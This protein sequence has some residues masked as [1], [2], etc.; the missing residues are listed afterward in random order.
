MN[1]T[2]TRSL[3]SA[4]ALVSTAAFAT[5]FH[6]APNG[7]DANPGTQAK[8]F[9]TLE[10]ARDAIRELKQ[11]GP[12]KEP[13]TVRLG[14]GRYALAREV[15]FGPEDSGTAACPIT[16]TAA[17]PEPV[18]LDG[19]RGITGWQKHDAK[20]WVATVPDVAGGA[21]R[22]RQLYLNGRQRVRART[23]NE[24]FLRVAGC[25]EGTPKTANYHKDCQTFQFKPG[26]IHADWT[27]L[28]DVEVI[29]YHFWTDSHLPIKSVDTESNL[30]T[31]AHKAGKTFT[32]DFSE[33]GARY[34]VENVFE[35]LD[36]PG[37]W[38]LNRHTGQ[39]F[40][41]PLPGEDLA[42]AEVVAPF[43]SAHLRLEGKPAERRYVEH[44]R[45]RNLSFAYSNFAF[46]PTKKRDEVQWAGGTWAEWQHQGKDRHSQYGDPLIV[47]PEQGNFTLRPD[48]PAFA[49]GFQPIDLSQVGPRVATGP[50]NR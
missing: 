37:E 34:I 26:D 29:V 17:G 8:P 14:G 10:R 38:Y 23:P 32:D 46:N 40:Y 42:K 45:F 11:A 44:V 16:Y 48:S 30:V 21:W 15:R 27:N 43:A 20:L 47:N 39:L 22:F 5:D 6:M 7:N 36:A 9:A 4:M 31:F 12:L 50:Q 18:V 25:P 28:S 33:D 1:T 49:L 2:F 24:G 41:Y 35:G 19:G 3:L 13:V